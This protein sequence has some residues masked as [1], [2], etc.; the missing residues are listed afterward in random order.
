MGRGCRFVVVAAVLSDRVGGNGARRFDDPQD[1]ASL[2]PALI[3][4]LNVDLAARPTTLTGGEPRS[5]YMSLAAP[6][7]SCGLRRI[8]FDGCRSRARPSDASRVSGHT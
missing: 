7:A 3:E 5:D 1:H 6:I 4:A 2:R 8:V